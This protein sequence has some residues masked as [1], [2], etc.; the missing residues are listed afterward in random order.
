L[1]T[2]VLQNL[3]KGEFSES[4]NP[5]NFKLYEEKGK[6]CI[7]LLGRIEDLKLTSKTGPFIS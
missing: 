2:L 1:A 5:S 6:K 4:S 3:N 7:L